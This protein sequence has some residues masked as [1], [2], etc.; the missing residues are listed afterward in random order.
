MLSH[1][2][3][4]STQFVVVLWLL[5]AVLVLWLVRG[6]FR[7]QAVRRRLLRAGVLGLTAL[8]ALSIAS[9]DT[10]NAHYAYLPT[11]GDVTAA[12]GGDRQWIELS[13]LD[14]STTL[15]HL[16][17]H[18]ARHAQN[19]GVIVRMRLPADPA[20]GF[21]HSIAVAYLPK[22][23]F[24]EPTRHFPVVYLMHGS[25]GR[26]ADWF[27]AGEAARVGR[28]L[29]DA[30][31]PAILVAPQMSSSWLDDSE[32]VDGVKLKVES[33]L[34]HDVIPTIDARL[35]TVADRSGRIFAG[36][37]AGGYCALNLGLRHRD[38]VGTIV[39]M[40]GYTEPTH[41]GGMAALFGHSPAAGITAAANTP[42]LYAPGL[43]RAPDTRVWL[44]TG[45][46]DHTVMRQMTSLAS[47][48]TSRGFDVQW[49][50]RSGG[51]TY[52]V[53]TAALQEAL[54]WAVGGTP[55]RA[56]HDASH[57]GPR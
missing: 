25:P 35:R 53:W 39:D 13:S 21:A 2:D 16:P 42:R 19:S 24:T 7:R 51:H 11:V 12:I 4:I 3:V 46:S 33:H 18:R 41:T 52:W 1:L 48:L 8:V 9:A 45:S 6:L 56:A 20:N 22:Q 27:H 34:F 15:D 37:S 10:V 54:P 55:G 14:T 36:M 28:Q 30:G 38:A 5:A 32:C 43:S 17:T 26:A 40:S 50:V 44:D 31:E 49:R 29:A 23:Y 57:P 47:V